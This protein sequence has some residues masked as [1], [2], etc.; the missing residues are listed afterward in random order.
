MVCLW[1]WDLPAL[2][3]KG[4]SVPWQLS[5]VDRIALCVPL[6]PTSS[7]PPLSVSCQLPRDPSQSLKLKGFSR[8]SAD[9]GRSPMEGEGKPFPQK[10]RLHSESGEALN[11][12]NNS[13]WPWATSLG[14]SFLI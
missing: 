12:I 9:F 8:L 4:L 3:F 1:N 2:A 7:A 6:A 10:G 11:Y 14:L 13:V 5:L